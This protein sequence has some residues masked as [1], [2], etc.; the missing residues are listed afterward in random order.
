M[1]AITRNKRIII[2]NIV[3]IIYRSHICTVQ[4]KNPVFSSLGRLTVCSVGVCSS[5]GMK[6][7]ISTYTV[8]SVQSWRSA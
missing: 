8:G 2:D 4:L 1:K 5:V 3:E 6:S 7:N